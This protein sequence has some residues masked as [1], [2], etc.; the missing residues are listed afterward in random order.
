MS[1]HLE[2]KQNE[3]APTVLITG[4]PLRA[5]YFSEFWLRDAHCYNRIRGMLGF[6][7]T[8]KGKRVSIQ[9]TGIGIPSTALYVHELVRS[10]NVVRIIRIGTCGAL[11][12]SLKLEEVILATEAATDSAAVKQ[13]SIQEQSFHQPSAELLQVAE[14]MAI[15][16][17]IPIRKG[18]VFS[19]DLFYSEDA[20]RY[21]RYTNLGV[22][23][24]DMETSMLYAMSAHYKFQSLSL[25]TVS[26]SIITGT[27]TSAEYREKNTDAMF[28]LAL[29]IVLTLP[30]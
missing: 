16:L 23:G 2:A 7:G 11:Q 24:V 21:G 22:L 1:L 8:Y 27:A 9:G 19:T 4:D 10:Y 3:I 17:N 28:K 12:A 30:D 14:E 20:A 13:Y 25:L 6:T 29:E 15:T 26:D 5:K 18:L